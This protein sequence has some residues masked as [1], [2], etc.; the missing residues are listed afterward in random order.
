MSRLISWAF[1]ALATL[2]MLIGNPDTM[3]ATLWGA[4]CFWHLLADR[5]ERL[6]EREEEA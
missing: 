4:A 3:A 1:A 2:R 6:K 5:E